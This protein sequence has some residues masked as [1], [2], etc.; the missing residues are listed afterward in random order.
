MSIKQT[1]I[2]ATVALTTVAMIAPVSAGAVTI[3]DL[4]AQITALMAQ[5]NSLQSSTTTGN[6]PAACVGVT[7][8]RN[9]TVG[10]TGSDVKCLQALLNANG[11]PVA[12]SGAGSSGNET[13]TF[14]P[15]TLAAVQKWQDAAIG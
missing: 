8:S 6:V 2:T 5:L 9:L 10:S 12:S 15:K 3:A 14:G 13:T 1:I 7:F 11:Y 4:Q